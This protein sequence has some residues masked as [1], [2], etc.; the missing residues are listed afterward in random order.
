MYALDII[1][2]VL[3]VLFSHHSP[4]TRFAFTMSYRFF[5]TLR[6]L[7]YFV[8]VS[9]S[10]FSF[11]LSFSFVVREREREREGERGRAHVSSCAFRWRAFEAIDM[12]ESFRLCLY[13][14]DKLPAVLLLHLLLSCGSSVMCMCVSDVTV[15]IVWMF[16]LSFPSP[17]FSFQEMK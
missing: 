15:S 2:P 14:F 17:P 10:V 16:F 3:P 7:V 12:A 11:F 13:L 5:A 4:I 8:G 9:E 6:L 1:S